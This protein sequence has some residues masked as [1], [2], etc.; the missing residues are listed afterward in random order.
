[1]TVGNINDPKYRPSVEAW[2]RRCVA[3]RVPP[4]TENEIQAE[5]VQLTQQKLE[6]LMREVDVEYQAAVESRYRILSLADSARN[7]HL[8]KE[9]AGEFSGVCLEFLINSKFGTALQVTYT[10][11]IRN[12]D[13]TSRDD[14]EHLVMTGL[15]KR[16]KWRK[17]RE[18]RLIFGEPPIED[19]PPLVNQKYEFPAEHL[20]G[21]IIGHRVET[22]QRDKLLALAKKRSHQPQCFVAMSYPLWPCV[23]LQ[24]LL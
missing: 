21:L 24:R 20:T 1:M 17:E 6:A 19:Q 22:G 8:W 7:R 11:A 14:F 3:H 16:K 9:Y 12:L 23:R 2:V 15:V 10:N 4:P 13:L 5:L 18:Y